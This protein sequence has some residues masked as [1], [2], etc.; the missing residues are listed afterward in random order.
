[1]IAAAV[2]WQSAGLLAF[3]VLAE[4]ARELCYKQATAAAASD[5]PASRSLL[6]QKL[7]WTG[8]ALWGVELVAWIAVLETLPLGIAFPIMSL[9]FA[10]VP[11]ASCWL[12]GERLTRRHLAGVSLVTLGVACIGIS[13]SRTATATIQTEIG[14][15]VV[16]EGWR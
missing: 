11:L 1:M 2:T 12:L 10:G 6:H 16:A 8:I 4:I 14:A 5:G 3:C 15:T 13:D 7:L 9:T